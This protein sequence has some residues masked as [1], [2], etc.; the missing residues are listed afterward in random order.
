MC[1][2]AYR[3][4]I[5]DDE[6]ECVRMLEEQVAEILKDSGL[7]FY[8]AAFPSGEALLS[9]ITEKFA[10]FDLFLLDIFMEEINGVDTAKALRLTNDSAAIIFTTVNEQYVFSGY[11][12]QALQYL[13]KPV[14]SQAL[15]AALTLDLKRRYKNRDFVFKSGGMTQK[16]PYD[17]IEYL[18]SKLKSVKLVAKQG[19]Y[20]IYQQI[21]GIEGILPKISFCR[22]HRSYIIN[23]R[24]VSKM[25]ARSFITVSGN[26]IPIGRTYVGTTSNAFLNYIVGGGQA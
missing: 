14:N 7:D 19:T 2:I 6:E 22:C 1:S 12:V 18:E 26:V 17:D 9:Y 4:A 25:N 23:F 13:L 8:I 20:E 10:S 15:S 5:C 11:E 21:S 16:V 3:V 24:Q